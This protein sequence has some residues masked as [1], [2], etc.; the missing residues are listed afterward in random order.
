[1]TCAVTSARRAPGR[2]DGPS[3][4]FR[5]TSNRMRTTTLSLVAQIRCA[6]PAP[7]EVRLS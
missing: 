2:P 5:G 1:M 7:D 3:A 6:K 4:Q